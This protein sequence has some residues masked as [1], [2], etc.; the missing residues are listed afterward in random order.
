MTTTNR[1]RWAKAG[2]DLDRRA[3]GFF[4]SQLALVETLIAALD[5]PMPLP[6]EEPLPANWD[7]LSPRQ[8]EN[9]MAERAT[10]RR[11]MDLAEANFR[12]RVRK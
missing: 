5:A 8:R 1:E 2:R 6:A 4:E 10:V 7:A 3:A 9:L 12:A 11:Q